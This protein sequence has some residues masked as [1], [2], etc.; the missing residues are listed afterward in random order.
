MKTILSAVQH[1]K[2]VVIY[3]HK[4]AIAK[5][6]PIKN[7]AEKNEAYGFGMWNDYLAVKDVNRY[8]RKL[9]K[10]RNHDI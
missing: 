9:R 4:R 1:G 2:E 3:S 5:I 6:I 8:V 10:G 7:S